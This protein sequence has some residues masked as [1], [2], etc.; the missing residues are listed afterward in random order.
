MERQNNPHQ[1]MYETLQL[2]NSHL[3]FRGGDTAFLQRKDFNSEYDFKEAIPIFCKLQKDGIIINF[4][5]S[6][7]QLPE[8]ELLTFS[9]VRSKINNIIPKIKKMADDYDKFSPKYKKTFFDTNKGIIFFD[10]KTLDVSSKSVLLSI[11]RKTFDAGFGKRVEDLDIVDDYGKDGSKRTVSD[12]V[13]RL[14]EMIREE[15]GINDMF[16]HKNEHTWIREELFK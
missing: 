10:N 1:R 15:F 12:G 3:A 6:K 16:A 4:A 7:A 14:N 13:S 5:Y 2:I 9:I 8:N 11:C